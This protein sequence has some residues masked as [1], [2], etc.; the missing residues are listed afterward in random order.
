MDYN[1]ETLSLLPH[2]CSLQFPAF[3]IWKS[4]LDKMVLDLIQPLVDCGTRINVF[5]K[6]LKE[7]HE[8]EYYYNLIKR[9][10]GILQRK[11][12][13]TKKK[14]DREYILEFSNKLKH[15]RAMPS[16]IYL[17]F[18]HKKYHYSMRAYLLKELKKLS[19][20]ISTGMFHIKKQKD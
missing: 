11:S 3:L 6:L 8:E 2:G 12:C 7:L 5:H 14:I 20:K 13:L 18:M 16:T 17:I 4:G 10:H 19:E 1:N 15:N 9:E